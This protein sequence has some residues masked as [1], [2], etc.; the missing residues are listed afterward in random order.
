MSSFKTQDNRNVEATVDDQGK[1]LIDQNTDAFNRL[2]VSSPIS[3]FEYNNEYN[4]GPLI[5]AEKV[6]GT[7]VA[8]HQP[9]SSTVLL[10]T[11]GTTEGDGIIRQTVQ[12]FRYAPGKSLLP[13]ITFN[14]RGG[15]GDC[16]K[17]AGYFD[18]DNGIFI[19]C[20]GE[21]INI[22]VRSKSSGDIVENRVPQAD[23]NM[24]KLDGSKSYEP[25]LDMSKVQIFLCDIQWLGVGSVRCGFEIDGKPYMCH[26]FDHANEVLTTYMATA[27]LPIRYEIHN[28]AGATE[29]GL[30]DQICATV[31][32]EQGS[33]DDQ[34]YYE[35]AVNN[36][37]A[38]TS[39]TTRSAVLSIRPK[40]TFGGKINRGTIKH[41][42]FEVI[43]GGNNV[44]WE[45][46]Y[47]G[48]LG[49]TPD[50]TSAGDNSLVEFDTAGTTVTGGE[51]IA[52]GYAISGG[53]QVR[54]RTEGK[55]QARYPM[56]LDVDGLNPRLLSLV[57]TSVTGTATVNAA[58]GFKEYY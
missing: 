58:I 23:W 10:S 39:V 7:G 26:K 24:T 41:E 8:T 52:S 51:V 53:G 30:M 48:T 20:D 13:I 54:G 34:S 38:A 11:G 22:V 55:T 43:T 46:V 1:L 47:G 16:L 42:F 27:N 50:W 56:G 29:A 40:A 4:K 57:V 49:G 17:R 28:K 32:T 25:T 19:E 6:T 31:I 37:I 5:W 14:M 18:T 44:L 12:Y 36:G 33:I 45:L 35:H 2:R 21:T 15:Q 9:N 3:Q